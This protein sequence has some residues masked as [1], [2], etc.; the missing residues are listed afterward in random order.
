MWQ[1]VSGIMRLVIN[2]NKTK[3]LLKNFLPL[4]GIQKDKCSE[5][6]AAVG[7][8][9]WVTGAHASTVIESYGSV[10]QVLCCKY[11][12]WLYWNGP[13]HIWVQH[14]EL[15]WVNRLA[16]PIGE[17][18]EKGRRKMPATC[19]S[20]V[21]CCGV[22]CSCLHWTSSKE[23]DAVLLLVLGHVWERCTWLQVKVNWGWASDKGDFKRS[24]SSVF[25]WQH[26]LPAHLHFSICKHMWVLKFTCKYVLEV[27]SL[28]QPCRIEVHTS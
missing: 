7:Q 17:V 27:L 11:R 1:H 13:Q 18:E 15:P 5:D 16:D 9:R 23:L 2:K 4:A 25:V 22:S 3:K 8:S 19:P 12:T 21:L 24:F 28:Q 20:W 10:L 26:W 6:V 14:L